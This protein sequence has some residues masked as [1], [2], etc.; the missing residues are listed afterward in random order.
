MPFQ[1]SSGDEREDN[2]SVVAKPPVKLEQFVVCY[3]FYTFNT[4]SYKNIIIGCK[5][6]R[7]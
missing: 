6:T 3:L 7:T 1:A 2:T 5:N 4:L